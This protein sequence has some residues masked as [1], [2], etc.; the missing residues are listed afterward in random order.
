MRGA[1]SVSTYAPIDER[2]KFRIEYWALEEAKLRRLPKPKRHAGRIAL[3]TGA[4]SGIGR[5]IAAQ[6]AA[7]GACV[8]VADLD[9]DGAIAA[10]R[11][12]GGTDVAIGVAAD[13]TDAVQVQAAVDATVLAFGGIDLVVNNAGLS[14]S[15]SLLD[16]TEQDWDVQHD[17]MAKGS[18]LVA[19]AAA[20]AMIAQG[21]AGDIVYV[22]SKNGVF[23]GPNNIGYSATK[24]DQAH[25]VRLLAAELG[26]HGIRV[27]GVNPDGVVRGSGIFAGRL[28][29]A[30]RGRL[31]RTRGRA[32]RVLRPTHAAETRGAARTRRP[33]RRGIDVGRVQSHHGSR[34]AGRRR[35]CRRV[36]PLDEG[37]DA[38]GA[39]PKAPARSKWAG[40][41]TARVFAAVDLGASSGRV[42]AGVVDGDT[43]GLDVVHRFPNAPGS[44]DGHLRWDLTGLYGE[45][46]SGLVDARRAVSAGR[47]DRH[48]HV[49]RRLR[50]ARCERQPAGRTDRVPRRPYGARGGRGA[51]AD[52]QGRV[53]PHQRTAVPPLQHHLPT[54]GG[55]A[56]RPLGSRR[57]HRAAPRPA[58]VLADRRARHRV[59]QRDDD[60]VGRRPNGSVG[61][62]A[63][64]RGRRRRTSAFAHRTT[65][66]RSRRT[67]TR[68]VRAG[69]IAA[70]D[71]RHDGRRRTTP[72]RPS[73]RC[74]R[75]SRGFAYVSSGTWSLVGIELDD[76]I[77]TDAARTAN[78]TNEGGVDGRIRFLRNVG[79]LWLLEECVR[80]WNQ[81]GAG[82]RTSRPWW[83]KPPPC[84]RT[85]RSSTSTTR[86]S[87]RPATCRPAS[88]RPSPAGATP[89]RR[90]RPRSPAPSS[91]RSRT[92]MPAR[93][94]MPRCSAGARSRS[95]TSSA[96]A[97]RTRC[98]AG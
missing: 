55:A 73:S 62:R 13:V 22:V 28:G 60:R 97:R 35:R 44:V 21:L 96:A 83:P 69:R 7:E 64:R 72:P 20:R 46:L 93:S 90:H 47:V 42:V 86:C 56:R 12:I 29:C 33:L 48:R 80:V 16:T 65:R 40:Q 10:A 19:Q 59:H 81:S 61:G 2:E 34:R 14:I 43:I 75:R 85:D 84:R 24:A 70:V 67:A 66:N 74:R 36:P 8:V 41:V 25:Q 94:P 88:P 39:Q 1:E 53:V 6:L 51:P 79:G 52:Q 18:F 76:P 78:F 5:A 4:A 17:V 45:V 87:S 92:P 50:A 71:G 54:R 31:R 37:W 89:S 32:R 95:S 9:G 49:G 68:G 77:V 63:A 11:D 58:R 26:E 57:A 3:V 98:S 82:D 91:T 30:A 15:K 38:A 23:A 27:N